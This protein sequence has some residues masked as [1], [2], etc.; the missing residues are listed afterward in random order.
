MAAL[1]ETIVTLSGNGPE[2]RRQ[3][4]I[5]GPLES[6]NHL[7]DPD[8]I[9]E[10]Y[11]EG[12][13]DPAED[14]R[15]SRPSMPTVT[16]GEDME[17]ETDEMHNVPED[18]NN[19]S[20]ETDNDDE[21]QEVVT[22]P[23]RPTRFRSLRKG[24]SKVTGVSGAFKRKARIPVFTLTGENDGY[25]SE[26]M[27]DYMRVANTE[28]YVHEDGTAYC[29]PYMLGRGSGSKIWVIGHTPGDANGYWIGKVD[30]V[31]GS[32]TEVPSWVTHEPG[33]TT[34]IP[35]PGV[36]AVPVKAEVA[37]GW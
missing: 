8:A 31:D 21:C 32:P 2:H 12:S 3:V 1:S 25:F 5:S 37:K 26:V 33:E 17:F 29:Y 23:V 35:C 7:P 34:W 24:F 30:T 22:R 11:K 36:K 4:S 18:S 14:Q 20:E 9:E 16:E 6:C 19:V 28:Y 27:G 13:E 15:N 10:L